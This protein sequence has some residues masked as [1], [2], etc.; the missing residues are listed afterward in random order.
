MTSIMMTT[1]TKMKSTPMA[2][3]LGLIRGM[4]REQKLA[5][6]AFLFDT[7]QDEEQQM[8]ADDEFVRQ[9]LSTRY[10]NPMTAAEAKKMIRESHHFAARNLK[11]LHD[12]E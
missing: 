3:Y 9:F 1:V 11:P 8:C 4:S 12:G 6:M 10:D 5:V 2:P 7:L